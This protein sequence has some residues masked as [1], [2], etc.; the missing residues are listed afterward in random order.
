M[1]SQSES[2]FVVHKESK[3]RFEIALS[4]GTAF[5]EYRVEGDRMIFTHTEVPPQFRGRGIAK[6]LVLAGFDV[7][8]KNNLRIVPLCS[9]AA[10]VLQEHPEFNSLR[11]KA[12]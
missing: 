7:S 6:R 4:R 2:Y 9:Y 3:N 1:E 10:R 11:E 5:A 12:E 8:G